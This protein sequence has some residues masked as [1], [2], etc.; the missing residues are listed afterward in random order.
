MQQSWDD[1]LVAFLHD[2]PDKA[3]DIRG[4]VQR[5]C[6][7]ASAAL[8]QMVAADTLNTLPDHLAS[9]AERVP[10]PTADEDGVRAVEPRHGRLTVFHPLSGERSSLAVGQTDENAVHRIIADIVSG[11]DTPRDRFLAV[12]RLL[13]DRLAADWPWSALLPAD[14]RI[15]DHTI[16]HHLDTT[17]GLKAALSGPQ[18]AAFLSFALGPVQTFLEAARS[19]CDLWSGS[20]ILSWL[21]FQAMLP[22]VEQLGPAAVVYPS[23][24]GIPLLDLWLHRQTAIGRKLDLPDARGTRRVPSGCGSRRA[25]CLPNRFLA[26]VPWGAK[27]SAARELAGQCETAARRGWTMLATTVRDELNRRLQ[28]IAADW[29]KRWEEQIRGFFDV[30]TAALPLGGPREQV[31]E[32][33]AALWGKPVFAEAFPQA[34]NVRKLADAIPDEQCPHYLKRSNPARTNLSGLWQAQVDLSARLMTAQRTVCHVPPA[35]APGGAVPPKCSLMGSYEQMGPDD[36]DDSRDFWEKAVEQFRSNP[37]DGSRLRK[38]ERF[39]AVALVKRF[40][41]AAFFAQE[42]RL[43]QDECRIPDTATIA[44]S[45]WLADAEQLGFSFD[46]DNGQ[47]LHWPTR[48]FDKDEEPVPDAVWRTIEAARKHADLGPP[49]AYCAVLAMDGDEMGRWLRGENSPELHQ[50]LHPD[51]HQYFA[52][53]PGAAEGLDTCR[54]VGPALHAAISQALTN[55]ALHVA[56]RIVEKH[57]GTLIYCGGDDLLAL[58]PACTALACAHELRL[59]FSGDPR[60]NGGARSGYYR[61]LQNNGDAGRAAMGSDTRQIGNLPHDGQ[62]VLVMGTRATASAGLAVVHYQEDLR[63]AL[64]AARK[65]EKAAKGAGRDILQVVVCRCCGEQAAAPCPWEFV[66]TVQKWIETFS[67]DASDRWAHQ[68]RQELPTL[69]ALGT[70]TVL[71]EIRRQIGRT[72]KATQDKPTTT[73]GTWCPTWCPPGEM[74]AAFEAYREAML[75][76]RRR[77]V[78]KKVTRKEQDRQLAAATLEGFVALCQTA[79]FLARG[80]ES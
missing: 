38:R 4:H 56:P 30:R 69:K 17:A 18:G 22:I 75:A 49:P 78:Q 71:A 7:Y 1:L 27:G 76:E 53:L 25:A 26:V 63:F 24:R 29:D 67:A 37:I 32:V 57:L 80:R 11:L 55:F 14:T 8:G 40:A 23:L 21:T 36:P 35:T 20:M 42:L 64:A 59:A 19:V 13:P 77:P 39:C 5:A 12:W 50:V 73:M 66:D 28:P 68:L 43:S 45:K 74:A 47:W 16:W 9:I 2:P 61:P 3:L 52:R 60:V 58:L 70:D 79:S 54:P 72:E 6:R 51:L 31:E 48:D 41:E 65:A 34:A 10:T 44:A 62:D 15:P 46:L 33:L